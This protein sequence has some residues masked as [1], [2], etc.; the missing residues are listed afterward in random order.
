M[1]TARMMPVARLLISLLNVFAMATSP[2]GKKAVTRNACRKRTIP[3]YL[4][5]TNPMRTVRAPVMIITINMIFLRLNLPI[6]KLHAMAM[7][8]APSLEKPNIVFA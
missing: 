6:K 8:I 3:I 2:D 7:P 5:E 4:I 1:L